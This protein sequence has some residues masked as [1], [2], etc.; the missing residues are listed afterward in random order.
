MSGSAVVRAAGL[1]PRGGALLR[2]LLAAGGRVGIARAWREV[3]GGEG[4]PHMAAVYM[5]E[6]R[7]NRKLA[8]LGYS[9]RVGVDAPDI[10][11]LK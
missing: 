1:G 8:A 6:V 9:G 11:L 5:A 2:L 10:V 7:L 3:W 4:R